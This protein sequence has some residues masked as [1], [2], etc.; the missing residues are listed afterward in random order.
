[1]HPA[2]I[3]QVRGAPRTG[4]SKII[5]V[6]KVSDQAILCAPSRNLLLEIVVGSYP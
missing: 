4:T 6:C 3:V 1:M 2:Y 5:Q